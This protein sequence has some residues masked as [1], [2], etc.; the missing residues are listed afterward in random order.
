MEFI[1]SALDLDIVAFDES[2]LC[3]YLFYNNIK[4][5]KNLLFLFLKKKFLYHSFLTSF[6]FCYTIIKHNS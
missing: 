6:I 4:M 5:K 3:V 2:G 1:N